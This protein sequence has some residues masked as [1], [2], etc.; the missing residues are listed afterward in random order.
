M[1]AIASVAVVVSLVAAGSP[2]AAAE[3]LAGP[4]R[5]YVTNSALLAGDADVARFNVD[6]AGGLLP[7]DAVKANRGA[8]GLVFTPDVSTFGQRFAYLASEFADDP[9]SELGGGIEAFRVAPSGALTR[10]GAVRTE[11]APFGIAI[12]PTGHTVYVA[13]RDAGSISAYEVG[14]TG[15]LTLRNTV[16]SGAPDAKGVTVTPDGRFV[17]VSHGETESGAPSLVTGVAVA[18]DGSLAGVVAK[19]AVGPSGQEVRVTRDGR[20]LYVT[21]Q[22]AED[23]PDVY[24]FSIDARGDLTP[25]PGKPVEAGVWV[26]G[27]ALSPDGRRLYTTALGEVGATGRR[28]GQLRGFAIGADGQLTEITR[29]DAASSDP[30]ALAF[31]TDGLHLYVSDFSDNL[32][33][34]YEVSPAGQ[35]TPVQKVSSQGGNPAFQSVVVLPGSRI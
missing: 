35:L 16:P 28:D 12:A 4:D 20:H 24:G 19:R 7:V 11:S 6:A 13:N 14:S 31:G 27:A 2:A 3:P 15:A 5:V 33:T 9:T 22:V 29:L 32:V 23:G 1:R 34:S 18:F 30:V 26:E 21:N 10:I 25:V 17:Y 8:R